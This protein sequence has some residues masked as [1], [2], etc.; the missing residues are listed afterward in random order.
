MTLRKILMLDDGNI[1]ESI[2]GIARKLRREGIEIQIEIINPQD[3]KFKTE[4]PSGSFEIDFDKIK[5][6]IN[7]HHKAITYDVVACDF[8]FASN[9]LNGY[10]LIR[11]LINQSNSQHFL[12]RKAKFVCYSS[13]ENKF[14]DHILDNDELFKLIKLNIHAFYHR[15]N[16]VNDITALVKKINSNFSMSDYLK[17]RLEEMPDLEFKNVYPPFK[18]K[19]LQYISEQINQDSHHA[20]KF[21]KYFID[22]TYAHILDL[23]K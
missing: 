10:E 16:L 15:K 23:N 11:W 17:I 22:L 4:T 20:K 5:N 12:F 8:N 21:Q 1:S 9:T 13:E 14:K 19:N 18:G 2:E 3:H 7:E 6:E